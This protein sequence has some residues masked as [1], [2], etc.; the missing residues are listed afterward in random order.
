[1]FSVDPPTLSNLNN[2]NK[3]QKRLAMTIL[4]GEDPG[5]LYIFVH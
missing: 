2:T 1:M 3:K 5:Q 4:L